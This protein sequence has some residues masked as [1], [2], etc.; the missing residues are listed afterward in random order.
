M[1]RLIFGGGA[2]DGVALYAR[3]AEQSGFHV[4]IV[5][6]VGP[7]RVPVLILEKPLSLV[8]SGSEGGEP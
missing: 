8:T 6:G 4:T 1:S 5:E 7:V 3:F 2:E